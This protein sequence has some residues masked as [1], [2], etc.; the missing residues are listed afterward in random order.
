[1]LQVYVNGKFYDKDK[2]V[3]SVFDHGLLY[4]DGV[5]E[6]MRSYNGKVFRL[7]DHIKRLY[8]SA[9]SVWID[10]PMTQEEMCKATNDTLALNQIQ[11][12]YIRLVVTRGSGTL[13]LDP[14]KCSNPSIIIITD[15]IA[16]YPDELYQNGLE[17]VTAATIRT[18]PAMLSPRVKS[19]NYLNNILAK[20]EASRAGSMEALMI[21]DTGYVVECTGDNIFLWRHGRLITP[22]AWMGALEGITRK[23]VLELA[24]GMG[25]PVAEE[26]V[27]RFD[28]Y[29]AEEMFLTG[30]A[31]ELIPVVNVDARKIG[32]GKP[33]PMFKKL[34]EAFRERTKE[35]D[36]AAIRGQA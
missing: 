10:I 32:D 34:L 24:R 28:V 13:G 30:T 17:M 6:G 1:M 9:R 25:F 12:G 22:P 36:G 14:R 15:S 16:L 29:S 31:A 33:G 35:T 4:G 5:F 11:N 8:E 19:L 21:N 2:A 7:E 20:I 23:T 3:V 18:S 26:P 27:S